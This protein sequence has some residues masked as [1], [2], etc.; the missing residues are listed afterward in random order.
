MKL[1][2][3]ILFF[4]ATLSANAYQYELFEIRGKVG[5]KDSSGKIVLPASF[6]NLGWAD[7]SF[8]VIG[9]ITG[10]KIND[11]WGLVNLNKEFLTPPIY[12]SVINS[13][14]YLVIARKKINAIEYKTGC[15]D[16]RGEIAI[17]FIFEGVKISGLQAIIFKKE[18][19]NFRYGLISLKNEIIIPIEYSHISPLGSSRF[20]VENSK[21][22]TS[23]F[24]DLGKIITPFT[25]DS[26]SHYQNNYAVFHQGFTQGLIDTNGDII[27]QSIYRKIKTNSNGSILSQLP[28]KCQILSGHNQVLNK[29]EADGLINLKSNLYKIKRGNLYGISDDQLNPIISPQ[30]EVLV[31]IGKNKFI[32]KKKNFGIIRA[33]NSIVLPFE[34]DSIIVEKELVRLKKKTTSKNAW[35]LYDTLGKPRTASAYEWMGE[36]KDDFFP[37]KKRGYW[38]AINTKGE[39]IIHC[40]YDSLI[41]YAAGRFVVKLKNEYGI[42]NLNEDWVMAPQPFPILIVNE[43][44]IL[45]TKEKTNYL[46]DLS[47]GIIYF[48]DHPL[49]FSSNFI[50]EKLYNGSH[51]KI[52]YDGRVITN[53]WPVMVE[54]V[55]T[56]FGES[57]GLRG[58]K[59][60]NK[61]GFVDAKGN[62]RIA[63]RYD[64]ISQ[65]K[66]GLVAVKLNNKWG[67]INT[68]E[69]III[70]PSY[71]YASDFDKGKALV[72]RKGKYGLINKEGKAILAIR[73]DTIQQLSEKYL[74]LVNNQKGLAN[75]EGQVIIE[76]KFEEL[77][78]LGNGYLIAQR[79]GKF[80]L[81]TI[82]GISTI[83]LIYD[84]LIY[85]PK[86]NNYLV[87][88][89]AEWESITVRK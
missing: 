32:A 72:K 4:I 30:Y 23:I 26:I 8:S 80:G 12:E 44:R 18:G 5:L 58:I 54:K 59:K 28:S 52:D 73:Y 68:E 47:G 40:V 67:Y 14:G 24:S 55:E 71:E 77:V 21:G 19:S 89:V 75:K 16:L 33:D 83:P 27:V 51:R 45:I 85:N 74:L 61:F 79:D 6:E 29:I 17:P 36:L 49:E 66:E 78:D 65:F 56:V 42:I 1:A 48:S 63:N 11:Q 25:I 37:V 22:Q 84:N 41:T 86:K 13:G 88:K 60:D 81:V 38:G 39:E 82:E 64:T 9:H 69:R 50:I 76:P 53:A 31:E 87:M 35:A 43:N 62:L 2:I 20:A 10:Y 46:K 57:E 7:G 34:F 15:L 70:Q 3:C